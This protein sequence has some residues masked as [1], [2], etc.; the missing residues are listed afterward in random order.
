MFGFF[1]LFFVNCTADYRSHNILF[2]HIGRKIKTVVKKSSI[3]Q[4]K[5]FI[6]QKYQSTLPT[7]IHGHRTV[8]LKYIE[9]MKN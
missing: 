8:I 6:F 5:P 3:I 4:I 2:W 7:E 9:Q 1:H